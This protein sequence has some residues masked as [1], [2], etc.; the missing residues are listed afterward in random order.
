M[1]TLVLDTNIVSYLM[2]GH[3]FAE[4][5]RP[6]LI[7]K[8]LAVS[9][10]TV[11]EMYEGAYRGG[12]DENK[13]A[14]LEQELKKY[15]VIPYSAKIAR[16]WGVIRAERRIQPI[17]TDDAWIAA[18]AVAYNCPLVTHNP[19]DFRGISNLRII[20]ELQPNI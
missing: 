17:S 20:T 16:S 2:R 6:H 18:A 15:L 9:F 19:N 3:S 12:W 14:A 8:R 11:A 7:G 4:R 5:Y 1:E 13:I 10:M